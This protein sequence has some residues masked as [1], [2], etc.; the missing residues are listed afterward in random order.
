MSTL[1]RMAFA[2]A[3]LSGVAISASAQADGRSDAYAYAPCCG[4]EYNWSGFY[5]G[6]HAGALHAQL[7]WTFPTTGDF[8]EQSATRF[9]GG[10]QAGVQFQWERIVL[11]AEVSYTWADVDIGSA[12]IVAPGTFLTSSVK[13]L[14][15][16]TGRLGYAYERWLAY[17]KAGYATADVDFR[18][19][20]VV[21]TA[22]SSRERGWTAGIGI[23]MAL[24]SRIS[25]GV[26]YDYVHL[27]VSGSNPPGL[28]TD[29]G[30]DLQ[31]FMARLNF[32]FGRDEP[33]HV[34]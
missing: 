3:V 9:A 6:G 15:L 8:F 25:I 34:K 20:G 31:T 18:S 24:T 4:Q 19:A 10:G 5:V 13:N 33:V 27:E 1:I 21:T 32:R 30:V 14:L 26:A 17:A 23:D 12:S 28:A 29:A 7:D 16:A 2:I 22:S 11:G